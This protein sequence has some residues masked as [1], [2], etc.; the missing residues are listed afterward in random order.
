MTAAG[1]RTLVVMLAVV[2]HGACAATYSMVG[3]DLAGQGTGAAAPMV[4]GG[5]DGRTGSVAAGFGV[6][7]VAVEAVLHGHDLETD[8]DRW[9]SASAGM[10]LKLRVLQLG[11]TQT[12]VHGGALRAL[13]L[14]RDAMDVTWGVGYTYGAT[15]A[16]GKR[17][18]RVYV[19]TDVE[20]LTYAGT[21]VSGNGTIRSTS[22]GLM[23]GR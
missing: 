17:G 22:A 6:G 16:V 1:A 13:V 2:A 19:D 15:F 18:V 3:Y 7:P 11:P 14:D 10:E 9:L 4:G 20:Q 5:H 8:A 23:I 12:F 21:E